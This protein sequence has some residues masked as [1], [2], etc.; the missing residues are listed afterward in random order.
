MSYTYPH[1]RDEPVKDVMDGLKFF[2]S[3]M[4]KEDLSSPVELIIDDLLDLIMIEK[5]YFGLHRYPVRRRGIDDGKVS[6][7]EK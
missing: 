2:H 5:H 1:I 4:Y 3:V 6:G 7:T